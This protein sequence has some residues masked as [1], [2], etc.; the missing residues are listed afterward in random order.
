MLKQAI[1]RNEMPF[2]SDARVVPSTFLLDRD[3]VPPQEG[4]IWGQNPQFTT[5][6][7][8]TFALFRFA[9]IILLVGYRKVT[10]NFCVQ[11]KEIAPTLESRLSIEVAAV[12]AYSTC[13]VSVAAKY[14]D[15]V[16]WGPDAFI[17]FETPP[18]GMS[19][20]IVFT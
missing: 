10:C 19:S 2:G 16:S 6:C 14:S 7:H 4:E 18:Q 12:P 17:T 15:S 13:N 3:P 20:N 11:L 5:Y 9:E 1:G 8:I